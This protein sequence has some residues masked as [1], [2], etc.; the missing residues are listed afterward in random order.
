MYA[1][2]L[3]FTAYFLLALADLITKGR[4]YKTYSVLW[5]VSMVTGAVNTGVFVLHWGVF[6]LYV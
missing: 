5:S 3:L 6:F 2:V 1:A 4:H